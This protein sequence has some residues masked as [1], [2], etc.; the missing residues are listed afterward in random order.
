MGRTTYT[1]QISTDHGHTW[2]VSA[3]GLSHMDVLKHAFRVTADGDR[4]GDEYPDRYVVQSRATGQ[5][6]WRWMW[7]K[8]S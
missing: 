8:S 7:I 5:E 6:G 4:Y 2:R 1:Y 3:E